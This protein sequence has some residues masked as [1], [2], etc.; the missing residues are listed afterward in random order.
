MQIG[1]RPDK[2]TIVTYHSDIVKQKLLL[3]FYRP[4]M[5]RFL[6]S[7]DRIVATSPN[8]LETSDVL[9][10]FSDKTTVIPLGLDEADSPAADATTKARWRERFPRPFFLFFGVLRYYK[11]LRTLL[12]AARTSDIDIVIVGGSPMKSQ[13]IA[14]ASEHN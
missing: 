11:G 12:A 1:V 6:G 8:Y 5:N 4:L 7:V 14:Y 2:P 3:Q 10:R 9:R 13:L